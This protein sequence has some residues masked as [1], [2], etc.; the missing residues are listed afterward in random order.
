M[1]SS[2]LLPAAPAARAG[3]RCSS[4]YYVLK[5]KR[6]R[7]DLRIRTGRRPF[8]RP[9]SGGREPAEYRIC[10]AAARRDAAKKKKAQIT[11]LSISQQTATLTGYFAHLR[12]EDALGDV[13]KQ[14]AAQLGIVE[15]VCEISPSL[16]VPDKLPPRLVLRR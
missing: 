4:K 8:G 13:V 6:R 7:R 11:H 1:S 15:D 10:R 12:G 16:A 3:S 9:A 14:Q 2:A 5:P